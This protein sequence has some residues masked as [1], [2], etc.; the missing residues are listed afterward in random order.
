M[1]RCTLRC[2]GVG[3]LAVGFASKRWAPNASL[4]WL[5]L[6]PVFVDMLWSVF[7]LLGLE[8]A[9]I[10]PG[11]TKAVPLDLEYMPISHSLL[12]GLGW[13]VVLVVAYLA[14]Q[15]FRAATQLRISVVLFVGVLSHWVLDWVSHRPDMPVLPSGPRLGLGLWNYP[16]AAFLV[17]ACMLAIGLWSYASVTKSRSRAGQIGFGVLALALFAMNCAA[18]T[19]PPPPDIRAFAGGN[20]SLL[21]LIWIVHRMDSRRDGS[22]PV[23]RS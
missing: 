17:E 9:R 4:G 6:A 23:A 16:L 19:A 8:R 1:Q 2:M 22:I 5:M 18:Y 13:A 3:H 14:S 15:R 21:I 10:T 20:I 12:G 7:V 11:I